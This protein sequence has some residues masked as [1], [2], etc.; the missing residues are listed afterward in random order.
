MP[1]LRE[2]GQDVLVLARHFLARYA[3]E[4][5]KTVQGF[6]DAATAKLLAYRWPGNVRELENAIERAVVLSEGDRIDAADLPMEVAPPTQA[7]APRVP[8]STMAEIEK[9]AIL[10]TLEACGGSTT[11]AAAMLD[12]SVRTIQYRLSQWGMTARDFKAG[13]GTDG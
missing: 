4:N 2:R 13:A 6:T 10:A 12:L 7:G 9:H 11:Q 3:A 5:G 1:P 8:G